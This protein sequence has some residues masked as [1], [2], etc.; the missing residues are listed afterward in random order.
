L[1]LFREK[2]IAAFREHHR[3]RVPMVVRYTCTYTCTTKLSTRS[4]Y[5][6]QYVRMHNRD[7]KTRWPL[8]AAA[9]RAHQHH[10]PGRAAVAFLAKYMVGKGVRPRQARAARAA[11]TCRCHGG[12]WRTVG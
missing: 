7:R 3:T 12:G 6:L 4:T 11:R 9:P 2:C 5:V 8:Q 10:H 1:L